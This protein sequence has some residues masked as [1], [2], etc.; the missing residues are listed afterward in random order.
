MRNGID[1]GADGKISLSAASK[2]QKFPGADAAAAP[3]A[4][5]TPTPAPMHR[6]ESLRI[7]EFGG[8]TST[9]KSYVSVFLQKTGKCRSQLR[10]SAALKRGARSRC[11]V[12]AGICVRLCNRGPDYLSIGASIDAVAHGASA[13]RRKGGNGTR[14]RHSLGVLHFAILIKP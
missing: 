5:G 3:S 8:V 12:R 2:T 4:A 6:S 1:R 11:R 7:D 9:K 13:E 10:E 14:A